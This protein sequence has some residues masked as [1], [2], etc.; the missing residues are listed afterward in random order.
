MEFM[1]YRGMQRKQYNEEPLPKRQ[2][3]S[4]EG[5][6]DNDAGLAFPWFP[7][8][9]RDTRMLL[10]A[11]HFDEQNRSS[12]SDTIRILSVQRHTRVSNICG[13]AE[14]GREW[15]GNIAVNFK[16][17][18]TELIKIFPE[19]N[20]P[21]IVALD[22]FWLEKKY[23]ANRYGC[24]WH[25]KTKFLF[26]NWPKLR[27]VILPCDRLSGQLADDFSV[28]KSAHFP[29]PCDPTLHVHLLTPQ[30]AQ[31]CHPLVVATDLKQN[32][33]YN[34]FSHSQVK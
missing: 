22:S 18:M 15:R 31:Q 12:D 16:T 13:A 24:N 7:R 20:E 34:F 29:H 6:V 28:S 1:N 19:H 17:K 27:F 25:S 23:Y 9:G 3:I 14:L 4:S 2:S 8:T 30:Q 10:L 33:F 26:D 11:M 21:N 5:M 32:Y